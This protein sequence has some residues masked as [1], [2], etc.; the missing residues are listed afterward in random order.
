MEQNICLRDI[1]VSDYEFIDELNHEL[2]YNYPKEK[3]KGRIE[4]ILQNTNNKIFVA[5]ING[6]VIGYIHFTPYELLSDDSLINILGFV[7]K[8]NYRNMG[9]GKKLITLMEEWAKNN[10]FAGVRLVSGYD[11]ENAHK[12]YEKNGYYNRKNQKNFVKRF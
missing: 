12:F 5:E 2:G 4:Y 6:E 7:I 10:N 3:V 11:R 8:S 9:I 1:K